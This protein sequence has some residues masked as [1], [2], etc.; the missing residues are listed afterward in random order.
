MSLSTFGKQISMNLNDSDF[1]WLSRQLRGQFDEP[2]HPYQYDEDMQIIERARRF[3]LNDLADSMQNDL[4]I[5]NHATVNNIS[6]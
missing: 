1:E 2:R 4:M 3:G 6:R 5:S